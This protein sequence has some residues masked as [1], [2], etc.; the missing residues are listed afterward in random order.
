M[1]TCRNKMKVCRLGMQNGVL[2]LILYSTTANSEVVT[3]KKVEVI[4]SKSEVYH[5]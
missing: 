4:T 2:S 5:L 1:T 3:S